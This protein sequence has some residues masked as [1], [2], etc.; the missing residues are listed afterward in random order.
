[1]DRLALITI[2]ICAAC[3]ADEPTDE[4]RCEQVRDRLID[5][6]L[7]DATNVD[8]KAHREV[9]RRALGNDFI[10][11]CATKLTIAQQRCVIEA[12]DSAS[13]TA[14]AKTH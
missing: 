2:L 10:A 7:A 11:R 14:C 1:M 9:M 5:L 8:V 12:R 13:A 3:G 6:R 4:Q